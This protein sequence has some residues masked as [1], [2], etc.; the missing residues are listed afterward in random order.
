MQ[1]KKLLKECGLNSYEAATYLSL[2][3][4]GVS[5]AKTIHKDAEVPYGKI[6]TVLESLAGNG[7]L[8]TQNSRPKKFKAVEPETALNI[9]F[10]KRKSD[11]EKELVTL[12][13]TVD[14]LKQTLMS[15]TYQKK[16]DD[17]FWTTAVTEDEIKKFGNSI[18]GEAK[19]SVCIIPPSIKASIITD[20]F[21]KFVSSLERGVKVKIMFP[22]HFINLVS[23]LPVKD[24]K[25]MDILKSNLE[26]R[27]SKIINS[28]FGVVDDNT[29]VLIQP[30]PLNKDQL[31]S[32]VKI[33]DAELARKLS[34]EFEVMWKVGELVDL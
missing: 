22:P 6:Y 15:V 33:W 12:Q 21:T 19:K 8:E 20:V 27:V 23:F 24:E 17:V 25:T 18:Y 13:N 9:Y 26:I 31:L 3:K 7:F 28:H 32:I 4:F 10:E 34:E 2:L 11:V 29:V 16:K 1:K 5:D 30:H 14:E